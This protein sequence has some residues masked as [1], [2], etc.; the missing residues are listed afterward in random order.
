MTKSIFAEGV[1]NNNKPD[2]KIQLSLGVGFG[3]F[4]ICSLK[5]SS[6]SVHWCCCGVEVRILEGFLSPRVHCENHSH[7]NL[8]LCKGRSKKYEKYCMFLSK[9]TKKPIYNFDGCA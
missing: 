3:I 1:E 7:K 6:R 5:V 8:V 2:R 9:S 4:K